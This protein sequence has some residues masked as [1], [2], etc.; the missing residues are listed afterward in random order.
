MTGQRRQSAIGA[1]RH[2]IDGN[3]IGHRLEQRKIVDRVAI[4]PTLTEV[5]Q[6]LTAL[7]QPCV[8]PGDLAF[9]NAGRPAM[10]PV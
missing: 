7:F 9:W 1:V 8:E 6:P 5:G 4:G 2:P 3:R 10:R